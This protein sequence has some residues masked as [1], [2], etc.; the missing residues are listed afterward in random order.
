M[1]SLCRGGALLRYRPRALCRRRIAELGP[2]TSTRQGCLHG[3]EPCAL[4]PTAARFPPD[5]SQRP[6]ATAAALSHA[7]PCA[8]ARP[9]QPAAPGGSPRRP[10]GSAGRGFTRALRPSQRKNLHPQAPVQSAP[11]AVGRRR[12]RACN[13]PRPC[14]QAVDVCVSFPKDPGARRGPRSPPR[15]RRALTSTVV[16]LAP[17][18][19]RRAARPRQPPASRVSERPAAAPARRP[20]AH[21]RLFACVSFPKHAGRTPA[22]LARQ[23]GGACGRITARGAADLADTTGLSST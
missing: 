15:K 1:Q 19:A 14:M 16:S 3:Q 11:G 18:A 10:R 9:L 20:P 7:V 21:L 6:A 23:A 5:P 17:R 8:R 2:D 12:P 4:P 22:A 13:A